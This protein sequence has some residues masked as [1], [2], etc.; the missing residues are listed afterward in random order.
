MA[1][2]CRDSLIETANDLFYRHGFHA[3]GLDQIIEKVGVTKTTFYKHFES[4]DDLIIAAL[5]YRDQRELSEWTA[6][7]RRRA[8]DDPRGQLI[9]F[10]DLLEDWFHTEGFRGCM[11]MNAQTEFPAATDPIHIAASAH[12]KNL[13][14]V[15][16]D[17]C[18]RA[19]ARNPEA[20]TGQLMMLITGA[21]VQRHVAHRRDAA[22]TAK[23]A[24]EL[25]IEHHI[26]RQARAAG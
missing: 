20:L 9:A 21:L 8:G 24:A 4:K 2:S 14:E 3:V 22:R 6:E 17:M 23:A 19:E 13:S 18:R 12:G 26:P 7:V 16:L 15:M 25:L 5:N 10:F 1:E 11:F